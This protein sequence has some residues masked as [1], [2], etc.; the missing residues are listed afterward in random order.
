MSHGL[1]PALEG[2]GCDPLEVGGILKQVREFDSECRRRNEDG[3]GKSNG[4]EGCV[5]GLVD[6]VA[7]LSS[8]MGRGQHNPPSI[9]CMAHC[10]W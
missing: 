3:E 1:K 9:I 6:W 8:S 5:D 7:D 2:A 10:C 4:E